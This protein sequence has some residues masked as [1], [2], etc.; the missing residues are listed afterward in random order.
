[1]QRRA[2]LTA[3]GGAGVLTVVGGAGTTLLS[4]EAAATAQVNGLD[5]EGDAITTGDGGISDIVV[6]VS[7]PPALPGGEYSGVTED[8]DSVRFNLH[9]GTPP[10]VSDP[11]DLIDFVLFEVD[12]EPSL[13]PTDGEIGYS[14][15]DVSIIQ[16]TDWETDD[17]EAPNDGDTTDTDVEFQVRLILRDA[18]GNRLAGT[19][20]TIQDTATFSV[21]NQEANL[22]VRGEGEGT[23]LP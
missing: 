21:T 3:V 23:I 20:L 14:F 22:T 4:D 12:D 6:D 17:F 9:V 2:L 16:D 13:G 19:P 15:A 8:V 11:W 5:M 18:A 1:M 7:N 10:G